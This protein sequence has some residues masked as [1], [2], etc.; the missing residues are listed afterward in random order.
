VWRDLSNGD[1]V[2]VTPKDKTKAWVAAGK[3]LPGSTTG[4]GGGF[5]QMIPTPA[6]S[7]KTTPA[8]VDIYNNPGGSGEPIGTLRSGKGG[9]LLEKNPDGWC[10]LDGLPADPGPPNFAGGPGWVWLG[11]TCKP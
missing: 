1:N 6:G 2:C 11:D 4:S 9:K 3:P 8:D 10:K 7:I 5:I